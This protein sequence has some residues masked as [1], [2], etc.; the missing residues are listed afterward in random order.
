M[1]SDLTP[2]LPQLA[3]EAHAARRARL[4]DA[5]R[6]EGGGVAILPNARTSV[7]NGDT[8]YAY[9]FDSHFYYLSGFREPESILV[10]VAG[11]REGE[12]QDILFCR[13]KNPEMEI[14]E[15]FRHG[16]EAAREQFGFH[17]THSTERFDEIL[18]DLLSDQP[19]AFIALGADK[20]FDARVLRGIEAVR[21]RARKGVSAPVSLHDLRPALD[22]MRLIKDAHEI[23]LMQR[24]A[25]IS[26][27]AH[28]RAMRV[29]RPGLFEY[30]VEA[31]LMHAFL[32]AGAASPA[33]PSIVAGG[34]NACTLHYVENRS[35]LAAGDL[36]LI[37]AGCE[38]EG[39][40]SDITRSFPVDGRFSGPQRA[41]YEVVLAAQ[42]A[43]IDAMRPGQPFNAAHE[44]AVRV[45]TSGLVDLGLLAGDVDGLIESGAFRRFYMH[46]TGHWLGLDVHDV[47][48]YRVA[49][50]SRPLQVGHVATVE[51]GL[52]IRPGE[53]VPEAFWN[54]GIR[55]EDDVLITPDGP[56][57]LSAAAPK[58]I[59]EIEA[60]MHG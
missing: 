31:E 36:L 3:P 58:T 55:I 40:A 38:F 25:D 13:D 9:R 44:V 4:A 11:A 56:R 7:R 5:M 21:A 14:W 57:V 26:A 10:I 29:T 45:I 22:G 34:A 33:Y 20:D 60:T 49:G 54:I 30:Q 28:A 37:D 1:P 47:G 19:T 8:E 53:D 42:L 12:R 18:P 48:A 50:A 15:G 24:A 59:A 39:Y 46:S 2:H 51:P 35:R 27:A 43:A 52:Y 17:V 23:A 41:A 6:A 32:H 16:P